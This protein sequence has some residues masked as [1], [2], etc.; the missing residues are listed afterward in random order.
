MDPKSLS[1]LAGILYGVGTIPYLN[2]IRNGTG[3]PSISSW[4]IWFLID[5]V[6]LAGMWVEHQ[7]NGLIISSTFFCFIIL[8]FACKRGMWEWSRMDTYCLIGAVLGIIL[9]KAFGEATVAII[10]CAV[11][12][13]IGA[14]PTVTRAWEDPTRENRATWTL[15]WLSCVV[16]LFALTEWTWASA[17]QPVS[18]TV[19]ESIVF[20]IVW[21][22]PRNHVVR[23]G[24]KRCPAT[25]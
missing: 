22:K 5:A 24:R 2:S 20:G 15:Y 3:R 17:S 25:Q 12:N 14:V 18:F 6:T 13:L 11:V 19:V 8:L 9:W 4:L 1:V 21:L 16:T 10:T 7:L 23:E